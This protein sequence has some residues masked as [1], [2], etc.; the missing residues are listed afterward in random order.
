MS[1]KSS[2]GLVIMTEIPD[3]GLVAVLQNRGKFDVEKMKKES[4]PGGTQVSAHGHLEEGEDFIDGLY[5]E[6]EEELGEMVAK[7]LRDAKDSVL[8]INRVTDDK[9]EVVT[10]MVKFPSEFLKEVK[11]S[12]S[13]AGL[14]YISEKDIASISNIKGFDKVEGVVDRKTIAMYLDE[15]EA[16]T[17]AFEFFR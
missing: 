3:Y 16:I 12:A 11:L 13:T 8:E 15:K 10:Y 9:E 4:Y 6:V 5:R 17:K 7:R 1:K 14:E 2:V